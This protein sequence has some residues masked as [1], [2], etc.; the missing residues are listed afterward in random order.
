[1]QIHATVSDAPVVFE[2]VMLLVEVLRTLV[3]LPTVVWSFDVQ[4]KLVVLVNAGEIPEMTALLDARV[5]RPP[6]TRAVVEVHRLGHVAA[7][8][9]G[10]QKYAPGIPE[11]TAGKSSIVESAPRSRRLL[12]MTAVFPFATWSV[13][14]VAVVPGGAYATPSHS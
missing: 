11:L 7:P 12:L 4:E 2:T 6:I 1:M 13:P 9:V 10:P 5:A 3:G 8:L 14:V